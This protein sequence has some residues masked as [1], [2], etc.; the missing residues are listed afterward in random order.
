MG[1]EGNH[2]KEYSNGTIPSRKI[3]K[4]IRGDHLRGRQ[5]HSTQRNFLLPSTH[6]VRHHA[7]IHTI[8]MRS[9]S[10]LD[11]FVGESCGRSSACCPLYYNIADHIVLLELHQ[12]TA[13]ESELRESDRHFHVDVVHVR[14][15][16]P[17]RVHVRSEQSPLVD[18]LQKAEERG[19]EWT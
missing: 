5:L 15:N 7:D 1:E 9:N 6:W 16:D 8:H 17:R 13:A 2:R 19:E 3:P 18:H 14:D 11:L 4:H 10:L 12:R